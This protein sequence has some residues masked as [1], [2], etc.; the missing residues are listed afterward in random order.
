MTLFV[1]HQSEK[2]HQI[3]TSE[4]INF[5]QCNNLNKEFLLKDDQI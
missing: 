1:A 5:L 4:Q 2:S 3:I